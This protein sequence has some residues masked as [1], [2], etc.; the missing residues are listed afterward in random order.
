[1]PLQS[2]FFYWLRDIDCLVSKKSL[3]SATSCN[4]A[5]FSISGRGQCKNLS[6]SK[7]TKT[8]SLLN[9]EGERGLCGCELLCMGTVHYVYIIQ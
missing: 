5:Y 6:S 1:M 2:S 7:D 4:V 9:E 3:F 8:V